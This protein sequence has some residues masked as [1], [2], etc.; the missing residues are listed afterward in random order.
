MER[1]RFL[2][3]HGL[4]GARSLA[5]SAASRLTPFAQV[6]T[7]APACAD[8]NARTIPGLNIKKSGS[9]PELKDDS[10]YPDWIWNLSKRDVSLYELNKQDED[11]IDFP[12][13]S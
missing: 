12:Q 11:E 13:V 3:L 8:A 1:V 2:C 9:D 7:T 5:L 4:P 6:T 10:E